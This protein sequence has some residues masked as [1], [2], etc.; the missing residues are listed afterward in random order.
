MRLRT[1]LCGFVCGAVT[2]L[3]TARVA[4]M[5][6]SGAGDA[7][8]REAVKQAAR[9]RDFHKKIK[10]IKGKYTHAIKWWRSP[11]AAPDESEGRGDAEWTLDGRFMVQKIHAKWLDMPFKAMVVLGYDNATGQYTSVWMDTLGTKMMFSKGTL[12]EAGETITMQ[13]EYVDVMTGE[14]VQVRSV[15]LLPARKRN[16][17]LEMYRTDTGGEEFKFLEVNTERRVMRGA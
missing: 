17:K 10:K 8:L 6:G 1:L 13:G 9:P 5:D 14:P 15:F 11:D 4:S 3:C 7:E 16:M 2:M 12:D